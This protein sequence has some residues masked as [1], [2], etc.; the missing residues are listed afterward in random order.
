MIALLKLI[1]DEKITE[2]V[3][4][5]LINKLGEE[6]YDVSLYVKKEGLGVVSDLSEIEKLCKEAITEAPQAVEEYKDGKEKALNFCVGIVMKKSKGQAKPDTVM[7]ILK[8]L[9]D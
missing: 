9:V 6:P 7:K 5:K 4:Q 8:K 3:G 2:K 1:Q